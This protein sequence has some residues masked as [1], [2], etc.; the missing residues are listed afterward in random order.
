[1]CTNLYV[2]RHGQSQGNL[3]DLFL[4]HT[5][6][7]LTELGFEQAALTANH[8]DNIPVDAIYSSDLA[9][10]YQTAQVTAQRKG[11]PVITNPALRELYA[12]QWEGQPYYQLQE[13]WPEAFQTWET[14][15]G[16]SYCPGGE[17]VLQMQ[18]RITAA[19]EK[20]A[21]EN[22]G[23]SVCIFSHAVAI[24]ALSAAWL[25]LS[26][27]ELQDHPW[28]TNSSVTHAIYQDGKFTL[29]EYSR[30]DFMGNKC[31]GFA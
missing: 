26:P 8:L 4:G 10:A 12:G 5:D 15:F 29:I 18:N 28:A 16:N 20:I 19:V 23:R 1:M 30:D 21:R 6:M 22:P 31:T 24:R 17:T 25:N 2:V 9:R 13:H 14:D 3:H 7:P 27:E 11:L